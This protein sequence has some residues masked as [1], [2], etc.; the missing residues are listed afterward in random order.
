MTSKLDKQ[1]QIFSLLNSKLNENAKDGSLITFKNNKS[2]IEKVL[3]KAN[4]VNQVYHFHKSIIQ[5]IN[6]GL[7]ITDLKGVI[8]FAN[9]IA[10]KLLGYKVQELLD[11]NIA[12]F[13]KD[14]DEA[15]KF[16]N[17]LSL[18]DKKIDNYET[19]F[20]DH[21]AKEIIIGINASS[22][23]DQNNKF[24]GVVFLFRDLTEI[25]HLRNQ[26]ERMERLALLGE[27]SAGIAH[28]IRNP[29]AGIKAS[30]QVLQESLSHEDF[31]SELINRI[32]KEVDKSN[33]LLKEFFKFARPLPPRFGLYDIEMIIDSVY[34][35]LA[36]RFKKNNI[37]FTKE[38]ED[39]I[40]QVHIDETQIEQVI[41]N[42][43][44][45]AVDVMPNGGELKAKTSKK[46]IS[47]QDIGSEKYITSED[48][49]H[50]IV[51]ISDTGK[52]IKPEIIDK[53][54]NPFFTTK[55]DGLGLGLSIC[56]RLIEENQGKVDVSST[57][58]KGTTFILALPTSEKNSLTNI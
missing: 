54:F 55:K 25:Y 38:F 26:V 3:S 29:L 21:N 19:R 30:A 2:D 23:N 6:A 9:K 20:V 7:F 46:K 32:V 36:P 47:L 1:K 24:E 37:K 52:G 31:R 58:G 45:N 28:E 8:T 43:F 27:L 13:F 44:L 4:F 10:G 22:L 41:L 16:L 49:Q 34:L 35:L 5:N 50:V 53:I 42:F 33:R 14:K 11:T 40:P 57:P 17:L 18:P 56:S 48:N 39:Q 51:E 12:D 15:Q